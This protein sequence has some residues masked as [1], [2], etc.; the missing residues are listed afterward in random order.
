MTLTRIRA[1]ELRVG[2]QFITSGTLVEVL[3]IGPHYTQ[4]NKRGKWAPKLV[5]NWM[6]VTYPRPPEYPDTLPHQL[7]LGM[8]NENWV[9]VPA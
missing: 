2:M 1:H 4:V 6:T 3:A 9:E 7:T 8:W 5:Q